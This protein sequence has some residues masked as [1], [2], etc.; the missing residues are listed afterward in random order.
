MV[1]ILV[2]IIA[3]CSVFL[4]FM[5]VFIRRD[6]RGQRGGRL[7]SCRHHPPGQGCERCHHAPQAGT[8]HPHP[9]ELADDDAGNSQNKADRSSPA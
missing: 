7:G 8:I 5:L 4:L 9:S 6:D 2:A 1:D 3:G